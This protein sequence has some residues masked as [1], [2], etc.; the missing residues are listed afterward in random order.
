MSSQNISIL[1][2]LYLFLAKNL[3]FFDVPLFGYFSL[4]FHIFFRIFA[5]FFTFSSFVHL[6][7]PC[8][9]A[10]CPKCLDYSFQLF[11]AFT[12]SDQTKQVG[13]LDL[14]GSS[15]NS[16]LCQS[17]EWECQTKEDR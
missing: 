15:S 14:T 9:Y 16:I 1:A 3:I 17:A 11:P 7:Y 8:M 4:I 2:N 5:Y 6:P 10:V 12:S 13:N